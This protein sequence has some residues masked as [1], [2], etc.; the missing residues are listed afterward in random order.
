MLEIK[1][2][3]VLSH[4]DQRA[5][6]RHCSSQWIGS[7]GRKQRGE[8]RAKRREG[9]QKNA[10]LVKLLSGEKR[11]QDGGTGR[12][13]PLV[14]DAEILKKLIRIKCLQKEW[15]VTVDV[16]NN[17]SHSESAPFLIDHHRNMIFNNVHAFI[18]N[19]RTI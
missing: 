6:V 18:I 7:S 14:H 5:S 12:T 13:R 19:Q 9:G 17:V 1:A 16:P 4:S 8:E 2:G 3:R 11:L 15:P 10:V